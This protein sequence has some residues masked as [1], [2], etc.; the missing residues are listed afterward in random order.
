MR[1]HRSVVM[2]NCVLSLKENESINIVYLHPNTNGLDAREA[3]L[4]NINNE[5]CL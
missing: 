2:E 3:A 4:C 1:G 5:N